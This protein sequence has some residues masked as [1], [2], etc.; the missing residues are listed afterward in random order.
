MAFE[1]YFQTSQGP[2][3][4]GRGR[5]LESGGLILFRLGLNTL[6]N[7]YQRIFVCFYSWINALQ[8]DF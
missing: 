1:M 6:W 7:M 5:F 8:R 3:W 4:V 2:V